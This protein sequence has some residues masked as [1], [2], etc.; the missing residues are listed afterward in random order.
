VSKVYLVALEVERPDHS[1]FDAPTWVIA[2]DD[3]EAGDLALTRAVERWPPPYKPVG[4][5]SARV[6]HSRRA[7]YFL[8]RHA[9][10]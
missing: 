3:S 4:V 10:D 6:D 8:D 9:G 2:E 7:R 1:R 5:I